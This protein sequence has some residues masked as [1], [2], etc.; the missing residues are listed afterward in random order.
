MQ[1]PQT[2]ELSARQKPQFEYC[3]CNTIA[4][5]Q[6][7]TVLSSAPNLY[8]FD[9]NFMCLWKR[10]NSFLFLLL[11]LKWATFLCMAILVAGF[12]W[13]RVFAKHQNSNFGWNH[14]GCVLTTEWQEKKTSKH[15]KR[16]VHSIFSEDIMQTLCKASSFFLFLFVLF[17]FAK[18]TR[19]NVYSIRIMSTRLRQ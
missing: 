2:K 15:I 1:Q 3:N 14:S 6:M 19:I 7:S 16:V 11:N 4:N 5:M 12:Y 8:L 10:T 13:Q 18:C 17:C 9:N